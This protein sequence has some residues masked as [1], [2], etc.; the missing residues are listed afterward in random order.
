ML[1]GR[2]GSTLMMQL[3]ATSPHVAMDRVYPFQNSYLTYLVMVAASLGR[4]RPLAHGAADYVYEPDPVPRGLPFEPLVL[5]SQKFSKRALGAM[6]EQFGLTVAEKLGPGAILYAEKYWGPLEPV[7]EAGLGPVVIDLVRDPRDIL[8]SARAFN[9]RRDGTLFGRAGAKDDWSHFRRMVLSM[10][11]RFDELD[12]RL[13]VP[14]L[15][16]RYEELVTDLP[17]T[18]ARVGALLGV[19]LDPELA[20]SD[21]AIALRHMT[22]GSPA[23]SI[24]RWRNDLSEREVALV[25]ARLGAHMARLGYLGAG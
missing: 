12:A 11:L 20:T 21:K 22:S 1:E 24:G 4:S 2:V 25:E 14:H 15:L 18:A 8:S 7:I 5:D 17:R 6:W 19:D 16:V 10:A 3:L 9:D 13:P 23:A